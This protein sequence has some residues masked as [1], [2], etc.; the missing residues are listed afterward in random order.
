MVQRPLKFF[1]HDLHKTVDSSLW[2]SGGTET[3]SGYV[4]V[5][6]GYVHVADDLHGKIGCCV[7][8]ESNI[9]I[10]LGPYT[11][12]TMFQQVMGAI[13]PGHWAR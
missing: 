11:A 6:C 7:I 13:L 5:M 8:M 10:Q 12:G 3:S 9:P 1:M 2:N 4:Y